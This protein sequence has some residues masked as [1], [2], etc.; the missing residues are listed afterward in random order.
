M[1]VVMRG[2][3]AVTGWV[4]GSSGAETLD[5]A[6]RGTRDGLMLAVNVAAMLIS[7][8]ALIALCN[9]GLGWI[10]SWWGDEALSL[11]VALGTP[12]APVAWLLGVPWQDCPAVNLWPRLFGGRFLETPR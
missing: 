1:Q 3:A 12:L 8:T 10:G 9:L 6:A 2:V 7:F 5:A 11:H 4:L